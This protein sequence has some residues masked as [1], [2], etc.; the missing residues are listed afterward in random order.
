MDCGP[1]ARTDLIV[2]KRFGSDSRLESTHFTAHLSNSDVY[3]A[4]S[5]SLGF[6]GILSFMESL[7]SYKLKRSYQI[8][9]IVTSFKIT[10][11]HL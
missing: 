4:T 7:Q 9:L 1:L 10:I 5:V 3:L 11:T 6:G 8:K 2:L